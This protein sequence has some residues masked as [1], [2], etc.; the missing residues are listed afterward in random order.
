MSLLV[1]L[2]SES[3]GSGEEG[4]VGTRSSGRST[5]LAG[6]KREEG[7]GTECSQVKMD[8]LEK[9]Y[10]NAILEVGFVDWA[11]LNLYF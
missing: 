6:G 8:N 5:T 10:Y 1:P 3:F 9:E 4:L 11:F 2:C 7:R